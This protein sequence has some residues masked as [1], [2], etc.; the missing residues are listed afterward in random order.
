MRR[1]PLLDPPI[2]ACSRTRRPPTSSHTWRRVGWRSNR[3]LSSARA[4]PE[5]VVGLLPRPRREPRRGGD[6][7]LRRGEGCVARMADRW[8]VTSPYWGRAGRLPRGDPRRPAR[9]PRRADR[10]RPGRRDLH[11]RGLHPDEGV[12]A[13]RARAQ[14]GERPLRPARREGRLGGARLRPDAGQQA[15]HR[16]RARERDHGRRQGE[17]DHHRVRPGRLHRR[18]HDRRRGGEDVRF[19]SAVVATGSQSLR[20]PVDGIDGPRCVDSTGLLAIERGAEAARDPGRR[21]D[22]RRVRVD[23]LA[24]SG[25]RSRSSRCSTI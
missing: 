11:H 15:G 7:N 2:C 23:L 5:P 10:G 21:R 20:P 16:R 8:N 22:R 24:T 9:R 25:P 19:Q 1:V 6:S 14:G 3:G 4:R 12:G 17:R 18:Q 13:D